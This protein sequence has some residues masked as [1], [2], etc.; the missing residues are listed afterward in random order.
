MNKLISLLAI[1]FLFNNALWA[2]PG[3]VLPL[4]GQWAGVLPVPGGSRSR[5]VPSTR[6]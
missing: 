6:S 2:E 5:V 4:L 3:S 1:L